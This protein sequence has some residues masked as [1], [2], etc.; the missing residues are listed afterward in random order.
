MSAARRARSGDARHDND[1]VA[2]SDFRC[3]SRGP[4]L[5][6]VGQGADC[7]AVRLLRDA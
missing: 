1:L 2:C 3:V 5:Q 6:Q 7:P 4:K